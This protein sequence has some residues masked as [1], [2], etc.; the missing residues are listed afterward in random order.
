[1][2]SNFN[3]YFYFFINFINDI[4]KIVFLQHIKFFVKSIK[5]QAQKNALIVYIWI[6][7]LSHVLQSIHQIVDRSRK[8]PKDKILR[9][10][11]NMD[12]K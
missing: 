7:Y 8:A 1:M 9:R 10:S 12:C 2:N 6:R 11:L 5:D 4:F 3:N